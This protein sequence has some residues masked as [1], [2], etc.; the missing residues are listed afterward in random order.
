[1]DWLALLLKLGHILAAFAFVSGLLGRWVVL[2]RAARSTHIEEQHL[3]AIGATPFERA[4]QVGSA[5]VVLLGFATAWAQHYP[6]LGLTTPWLLVSML[7]VVPML[8]F[9]PAIFIPQGRAFERAMA[10]AR[11]RG[12]I[13][14]ALRAAW[15][16]PFVAF[17]RRYE[18]IA[19][20]LIVAL[21][22]LKPF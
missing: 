3:L 12:I 13:T 1:V 6:W 17:A 7:L 10:D 2:T 4:V 15:R 21:M 20:V 9:V 18:L 16:N 14:P 8:L 11:A 19:T 22:V 5:L